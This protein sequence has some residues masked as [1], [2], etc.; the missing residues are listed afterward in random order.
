MTFLMIISVMAWASSSHHQGSRLAGSHLDQLTSICL[1]KE[2][3]NTNVVL[4]GS[5]SLAVVGSGSLELHSFEGD[6]VLVVCNRAHAEIATGSDGLG[7]GSV[8][9]A[10]IALGG[11]LDQFD[12]FLA[13]GDPSRD[14]E[15]ETLHVVQSTIVVFD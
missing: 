1:G 2:F 14:T 8:L 15:Q 12:F 10:L 11:V 7:L 3:D 4:L 9:R 5:S 13:V 6:N